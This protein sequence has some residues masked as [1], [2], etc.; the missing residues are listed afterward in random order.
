M[1][2]KDFCNQ[3]LAEYK[4]NRI[5]EFVTEMPKTISGKVQKHV[6]RKQG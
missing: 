4:W 5:V 3:K 6:Q 2:I 1:E